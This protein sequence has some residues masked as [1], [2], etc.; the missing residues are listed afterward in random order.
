MKLVRNAKPSNQT[1]CQPSQS[2]KMKTSCVS[3]FSKAARA[4]DVCS[5]LNDLVGIPRWPW[6]TPAK[7]RTPAFLGEAPTLNHSAEGETAG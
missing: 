5:F 3:Q 2:H 7:L 1:A 4:V 6:A